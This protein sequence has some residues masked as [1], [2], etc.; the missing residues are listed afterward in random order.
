MAPVRQLFEC[1]QCRAQYA[2]VNGQYVER[3]VW[4]DEA[5]DAVWKMNPPRVCVVTLTPGPDG[6]TMNFGVANRS[7]GETASGS[8]TRQEGG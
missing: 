2:Y 3:S 5:D 4:G 8:V 7:T 1:Q 6:R